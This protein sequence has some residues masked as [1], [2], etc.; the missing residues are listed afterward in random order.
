MMPKKIKGDFIISFAFLIF[1]IIVSYYLILQEEPFFNSLQARIYFVLMTSSM[2]GFVSLL[3]NYWRWDKSRPEKLKERFKQITF[4]LAVPYLFLVLTDWGYTLFLMWVMGI[5]LGLS[6]AEGIPVFHYIKITKKKAIL[7][8]M[9]FVLLYWLIK[10]VYGFGFF[11]K[12]IFYIL[13]ISHMIS[14]IISNFLFRIESIR[15]KLKK[16][17]MY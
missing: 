17:K 3:E 5:P 12:E 13:L 9:L 14:S 4:L 7:T 1:I 16:K 11:Q 8:A 15:K 10:S 2:L 6:V